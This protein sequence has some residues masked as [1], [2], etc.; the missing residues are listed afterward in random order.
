MKTIKYILLILVLTVTATKAEAKIVVTEHMYIFGFSASFNDST[1]YITD[2]QDVQGASYDTKK[3]FLLGRENYSSQLKEFLAEKKGQPNRVCM[4]LFATTK[5]KAE[6]KYQKLK[7][8]YTG[9]DGIA[10]G[11]HYLSSDEFKFEVIISDD[12]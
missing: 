3:E 12:F 11:L 1:L 7:K 2:I 10:Y 6:K 8:K 5:K 9:K 4:V